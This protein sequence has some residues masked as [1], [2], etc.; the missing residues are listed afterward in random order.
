MP[1]LR[2][3]H[4]NIRTAQLEVM[5]VFYTD[6]LE[7]TLGPRPDFSFPGAWLYLGDIAVVHLVGVA[8]APEPGSDLRLEHAA[9]RA[10]GLV[11]FRTKLEARGIAHSLDPVPGVPIVQVNLRDPDGNHLHVDFD[12]AEAPA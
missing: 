6:V 1:L 3:D 10:E 4:V 2:F 11:A 8:K 9:F 5:V 7:M 12:A